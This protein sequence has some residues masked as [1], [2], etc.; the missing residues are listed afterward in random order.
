MA[1]SHQAKRAVT[2]VIMDIL[3]VSE[4]SFGLYQAMHSAEDLTCV[5]LRNYLPLFIPTVLVFFFL[6]RRQKNVATAAA[7]SQQS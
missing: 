6:L 7:A 2:L 1:L 4:L 5:F 3:L